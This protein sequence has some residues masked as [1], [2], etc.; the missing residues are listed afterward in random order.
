MFFCVLSWFHDVFG[1][2]YHGFYYVYIAMF[3]WLTG[4]FIVASTIWTYPSKHSKDVPVNMSIVVPFYGV[5]CSCF[6]S[7]G[8]Y[9]LRVGATVISV[10]VV[11]EWKGF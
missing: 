2:L 8:T 6:F 3:C 9:L 10:P 7:K 11:F 5:S 4:P 1:R